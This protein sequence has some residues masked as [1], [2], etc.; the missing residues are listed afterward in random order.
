M[1]VVSVLLFVWGL[2]GFV[3]WAE[4]RYPTF[5]GKRIFL[6]GRSAPKA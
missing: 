6:N 4:E 2:Y 5:S 1:I 3:I